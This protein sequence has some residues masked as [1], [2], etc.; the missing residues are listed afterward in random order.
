MKRVFFGVFAVILAL[1]ALGSCG[2]SP[3]EM[4]TIAANE[5]AVIIDVRTPEEFA[6]GHVPGSFNI[7]LDELQ[8][9]A[10]RRLPDLYQEILV[11]CQSGNRSRTALR[12]LEHMGYVNV[13]DLGGI[14]SWSG[15]LQ[16]TN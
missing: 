3:E 6:R 10:L 7:P 14:V 11:I 8:D 9:E 13:T 5:E 15:E 1:F 12:A 2:L 16:T 4:L